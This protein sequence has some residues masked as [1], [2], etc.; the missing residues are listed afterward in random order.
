L[1]LHGFGQQESAFEHF[2]TV[3]QL[4][5]FFEKLRFSHDN[6]T[7]TWWCRHR[8]SPLFYRFVSLLSLSS[9]PMLSAPQI[10]TF[11]STQCKQTLN[12]SVITIL[13][14]VLRV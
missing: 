7:H 8:L 9:S 4:I 13:W 11:S 12:T 2:E 10:S 3:N 5:R 6:K 1:N 14:R